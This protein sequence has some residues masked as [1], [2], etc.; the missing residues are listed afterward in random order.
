MNRD[1][2]FFS[3]KLFRLDAL[4]PEIDRLKAEGKQIVF[5]NGIFDIL[6]VGHIRYLR[7]AKKHGDILVVGVNGDASARKLKGEG[8][9]FTNQDERLE[10]LAGMEPIDY[11]ILFEDD[12]VTKLLLTLK[13]HFHA[14]G[15]DYTVDSVPERET[16]R[17]YGGEVIICGDPKSHSSS[18][19]RERIENSPPEAET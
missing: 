12:D 10:V 6:H 7:S 16:V 3:G 19:I 14:K 2:D 9:P 8:R 13:P 1:A 11:L 15:T 5:A 18:V 17:S 4:V